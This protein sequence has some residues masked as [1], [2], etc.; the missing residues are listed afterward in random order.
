MTMSSCQNFF[1]DEKKVLDNSLWSYNN[2]LDFE[3]LIED[4]ISIYNIYLEIVHN[5]EYT[6][7]NIYS[8][9][10]VVFPDATNREDKVSMELADSKGEWLGIC[11]TKKCTRRIPFMPNAVFDQK[12]KYKIKFEQFTRSKV[13]EGIQSLRLIIEKTHEKKTQV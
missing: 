12:G 4:T 3:F 8:K 9:V 7:Q 6:Y 1:F 2:S 5:S 11:N 10:T 13:V